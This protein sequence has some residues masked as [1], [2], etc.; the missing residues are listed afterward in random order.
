M[1]E[2]EGG[3]LAWLRMVDSGCSVGWSHLRP[4]GWAGEQSEGGCKW[5]GNKFLRV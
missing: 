2:Q 5:G 1:K 3:E 4:S